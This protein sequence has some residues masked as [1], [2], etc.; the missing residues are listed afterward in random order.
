MNYE[1]ILKDL[2][3]SEE[4]VTAVNETTDKEN[5]ITDKVTKIHPMIFFKTDNFLLHIGF[6]CLR[7]YLMPK[8]NMTIREIDN[9]H[10]VLK[11]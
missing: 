5:P 9:K 11:K 1:F 8:K 4:E 2:K 6:S 10:L 3:P 7:E